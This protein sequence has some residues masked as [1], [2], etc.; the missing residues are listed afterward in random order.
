MYSES[1]RACGKQIAFVLL[2]EEDP[3]GSVLIAKIA[4]DHEL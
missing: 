3:F 4:V 1:S 2:E